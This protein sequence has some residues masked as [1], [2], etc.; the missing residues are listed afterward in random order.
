MKKIEA[1]IQ[2]FRMQQVFD[3]IKEAGLEGM[4]VTDVKGYGSQIGHTEVYRGTEYGVDFQP[5]TKVEVVVPD[6]LVEDVIEALLN[7]ARTGRTGDGK[8]FVCNVEEA[9]RIR[10]DGRGLAAI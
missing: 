7:A 5:R 3:A 4:M 2:P 8:I 10:N 1:I 6:G 9:I